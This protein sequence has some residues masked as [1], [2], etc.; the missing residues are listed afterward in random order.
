MPDLKWDN[1]LSKNIIAEIQLVKIK[2]DKYFMHDGNNK[3]ML[4]KSRDSIFPKN[5]NKNFGLN[6]SFNFGI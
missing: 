3:K 1:F 5:A 2:N 4:L 6:L